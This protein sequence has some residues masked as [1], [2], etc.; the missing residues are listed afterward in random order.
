MDLRR[1]SA[2]CNGDNFI[3]KELENLLHKFFLT[4][5]VITMSSFENENNLKWFLAFMSREIFKVSECFW[6]KHIYFQNVYI[7]NTYKTTTIGLERQHKSLFSSFPIASNY[8]SFSRDS[9]RVA[10]RENSISGHVWTRKAET[11]AI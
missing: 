11:E 4:W 9:F 3:C 1:I 6:F 10:R 5:V 8:Y 7:Y 2:T